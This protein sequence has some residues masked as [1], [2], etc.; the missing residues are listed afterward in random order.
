MAKRKSNTLGKQGR[1]ARVRQPAKG[2]SYQPSWRVAWRVILIAVIVGILYWQWSD[3]TAW[4][5]DI[6]DSTWNL[7]GWGL[8]LLIIALIILGVVLW[9][10]RSSSLL[11]RFR[12]W[13]G[14]I[15]FTMAI[16]GLL[17]FSALGGSI[18]QHLIG[19]PSNFIGI[20]RV[21]GL[22]IAGIVLVAPRAFVGA[23]RRSASWSHR[24]LQRQPKPPPAVQPELTSPP[25]TIIPPRV[26]AEEQPATSSPA[27]TSATPSP[28]STSH[29]IQ[30]P[31]PTQ[32]QEELRQVAQDVWRKYGE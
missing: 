13:L 11:V 29:P 21:V 25:I 30:P 20:P 10:R 23:F 4:V 9:L 28:V 32:P 26:T 19:Y 27:P 8:L 12:Q 18:G 2:H 3:L 1:K 31:L 24:Q 22:I 14:G 16:W 7:F 15:A 5:I 6:R 17:A